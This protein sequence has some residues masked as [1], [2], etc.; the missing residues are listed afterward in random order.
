MPF[1]DIKIVEQYQRNIADLIRT[2]LPHDLVDE[3]LNDFDEV[4]CE[5]TLNFCNPEWEDYYYTDSH[6]LE[7]LRNILTKS[8]K[9]MQK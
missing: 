2:N 6:K 7:I 9:Y 4:T 3:F 5:S 8:F 1:V